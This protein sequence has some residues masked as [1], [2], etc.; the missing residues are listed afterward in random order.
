MIKGRKGQHRVGLA[1]TE[2]IVEK[3]GE[4]SITIEC[5]SAR[6]LNA[7]ISIKLNFVT[8]VRGSL[9]PVQGS[10]R[11]AEGQI[12]DSPQ[13]R[14]LISARSGILLFVL[15]GANARTGKRGEG[16]E[17]TD[18][19]VLGAY[20][21]DKLNE[22]GKLL[23]GSAEDNKLALLNTFFRTPKSGV[24]Y[25]FQSVNRSKGQASLD[26]ILTKQADRRLIHCVNVRR[27][28][29]EAPESD[30]KLVYAKFASHAGL[31]QTGGRGT[32]SRKLQSWP[33]LGS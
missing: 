17:D 26:Y 8:S 19:E 18:S 11:G 7:R 31:H 30:N 20:G 12:H 15:T 4:D 10:A 24:S 33:T 29:L 27:P 3:A 1:L 25:T 5:I 21:R 16:G 23:L 32:L 22:N 28:P 14:R 2:E 13:L 6:L 9:C